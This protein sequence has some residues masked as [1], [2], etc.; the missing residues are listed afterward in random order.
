MLRLP[1]P[2]AFGPEPGPEQLSEPTERV[3]GRRG[4]STQL[5]GGN[6]AP[7][8]PRRPRNPLFRP[9]GA[10]NE[11]E[12]TVAPLRSEGMSRPRAVDSS[13]PA[14]ERSRRGARR[15]GGTRPRSALAAHGAPECQACPIGLA[16]SAVQS[17][18][19]E[20]FDHLVG[21]TRELVAAVRSF[22][23][24]IEDTLERSG[25][26]TSSIAR[27]EHFEVE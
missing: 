13:P 17:A 3:G 16:F 4:Q 7:F 15:V 26:R 20:T 19:P 10:D 22:M 2:E 9:M 12:G 24:G 5:V 8:V 1:D 6:V 18:R 25:S 21:A 27:V 11:Y 14:E 23:E